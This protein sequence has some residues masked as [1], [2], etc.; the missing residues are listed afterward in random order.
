GG[1]REYRLLVV[2]TC[3]RTGAA[4]R[5]EVDVDGGLAM[6]AASMPSGEA[7][8]RLDLGE[9]SSGFSV[10]RAEPNPVRDEVTLTFSGWMS[11]APNQPYELNVYSQVGLPV[12]SSTVHAGD[13]RAVDVRL[14]PA[15]VYQVLVRGLNAVACTSFV[16]MR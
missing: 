15:G 3:A 5:E 11:A 8:F 2:N 1:G 4:Y 9:E 6:H 10:V 7:D 12:Y 16:V 14:L 13:T